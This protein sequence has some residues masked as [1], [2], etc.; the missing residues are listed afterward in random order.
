LAAFFCINIDAWRATGEAWRTQF[1]DAVAYDGDGL[2]GLFLYLASLPWKLV[3]AFLPPPRL[4]GG[5]VCFFFSLVAIGVLTAFIGDIASHMGCCLGISKSI[6][7]ITFVALGTSL[8]DTFASKIAAETEPHA[9]ASLGNVT[10]SNAVNVFLGLGLP[11]AFAAVYW[12]YFAT[13]QEAEWRARYSGEPWYTT[14]MPVGFVVPA[15]D[16]GF[17]VAVF[18]ACA[19]ICLATLALRRLCLGYELGKAY[20]LPTVILFGFLWLVY[21][22]ASIAYSYHLEVNLGQLTHWTG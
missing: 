15:A 2:L 10:G 22:G 6:T 21:I 12:S 16:L 8:P 3:L 7:A 1:V 14:D 4:G 9:D 18:S 11:W 19:V 17:S 20:V 5:S 13:T